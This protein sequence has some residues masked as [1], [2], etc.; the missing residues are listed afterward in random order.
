MN[1]VACWFVE[2]EN[3]KFPLELIWSKCS[4]NGLV[5][6]V[7]SV[8]ESLTHVGLTSENLSDSFY[9]HSFPVN[10]LHINAFG[11]S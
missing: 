5:L 6:A 9:A 8:S 10:I 11:V 4:S 2:G 3:S 7:S 1:S